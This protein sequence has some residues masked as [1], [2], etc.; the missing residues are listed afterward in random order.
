MKLPCRNAALDLR[1]QRDRLERI[2]ERTRVRFVQD[3]AGRGSIAS[4]P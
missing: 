3:R 1:S 4:L 2:A